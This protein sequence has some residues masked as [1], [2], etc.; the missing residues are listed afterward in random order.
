MEYARIQ[1]RESYAVQTYMTH[2]WIVRDIRSRE[3]VGFTVG[4]R[5]S[6]LLNI[7]GEATRSRKH[8]KP[9]NLSMSNNTQHEVMVD[10]VDFDGIEVNYA[11]LLPGQDFSISTYEYHTW[12]VREKIF[13]C[14]T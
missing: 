10:W 6:Q 9:V 8:T 3:T 7:T 2:P 14:G 4:V 1:A 12:R 11:T 13:T 5:D